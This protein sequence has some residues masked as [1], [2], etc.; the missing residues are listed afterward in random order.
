MGLPGF[1]LTR[2]LLPSDWSVVAE[3]VGELPPDTLL[4]D[5]D[6]LRSASVPGGEWKVV[7]LLF[8]MAGFIVTDTWMLMGSCEAVF[9]LE[10][11]EVTEFSS[12]DCLLS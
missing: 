1:M 11:L 5:L 7:E 9:C 4:C 10:S 6:L 2:V 8:T 12:S 3:L